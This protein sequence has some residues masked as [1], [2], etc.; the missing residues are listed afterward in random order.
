[1]LVVVG[2]NNR[3][4]LAPYAFLNGSCANM[5]A[6]T[7][8]MNY[9]YQP[10]F[11]GGTQ[12]YT[13]E[14][15]GLPPGLMIDPDT[16]EISGIP[17]EEG[18]F[19]V[20][21]IVT[22]ASGRKSEV[23]CG[24]FE[25][26]PADELMLDC[27]APPPAVQGTTYSF[28][29][30]AT[31]GT[32]PFTWVVT[33]LPADLMFDP[34]TGLIS[35]D[36]NDAVGSYPI[37]ISVTDSSDPPATAECMTELE[38][39]PGLSVDP[40][41]L[42]DLGIYPDNCVPANSGIDIDQL[43]AD[44]IVLGGDGS[45][46]TCSFE[47]VNNPEFPPGTGQRGH[48]NLPPGITQNGDCTAVGT[49][50]ANEPH[51]MYVWIATLTQEGTGQKGYVPYCAPQMQQPGGAYD[52]SVTQNGDSGA[53]FKPGYA[54]MAGASFSFGDGSPD[55]LVEVVQP[56]TSN[57]CYY[58]FFFGYNTLSGMGGVN[59][60]PN[61]AL[62]GNMGLSHALQVSDSDIAGGLQDR[63]WV[64]NTEWNYCLFG[65]DIADKDQADAANEAQ[66]G[67]KDLAIQNGSGSNL[68]FGVIVRP[69][70]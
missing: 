7:Q 14:A 47:A 50:S 41:P 56:C 65:T 68:E 60:N 30:T 22:D 21:I 20:V 58:K 53:K 34:E 42:E 3:D 2:C 62:M 28:A 29:P 4:P 52:I 44:G 64:V 49:V 13:W 31:G 5:P 18:L 40:N 63:F 6:A 54:T 25:V 33:G 43:L 67:T 61:A 69:P 11:I 66:C 9:S 12:P 45:P 1:M 59:A 48:G 37:T 51:G 57:R 70:G 8:G 17:S 36:V 32:P 35:G 10:D 19:D 38:V 46:I 23:A 27:V 55:P 15:V 16:G 24:S 39:R 26:L